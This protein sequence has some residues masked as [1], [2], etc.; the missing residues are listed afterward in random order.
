[1]APQ[2]QGCQGFAV[3]ILRLW[4]QVASRSDG[5]STFIRWAAGRPDAS[6]SAD[7]DEFLLTLRPA[8]TS[9]EEVF[10]DEARHRA[11]M[12]TLGDCLEGKIR[13]RRDSVLASMDSELWTREEE[14]EALEKDIFGSDSEASPVAGEVNTS[15]LLIKPPDERPLSVP[16]SCECNAKQHIITWATSAPFSEYV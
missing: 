2:P 3:H 4:L 16:F 1:M 14:T 5:V 12:I 6:L 8:Y 13:A 15:P 7:V 9:W 11:E 10:A